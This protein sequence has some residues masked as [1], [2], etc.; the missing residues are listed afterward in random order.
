VNDPHLS[1][2]DAAE[3]ESLIEQIMATTDVHPID[4]RDYTRDL[5]FSFFS[6]ASDPAIELVAR[7]RVRGMAP[8]LLGE[9]ILG[10]VGLEGLH[11]AFAVRARFAFLQHD[12]DDLF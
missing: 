9:A 12:L 10:H 11:R 4:A 7:L 2:K 6:K 5:A 1:R 8:R 3:A